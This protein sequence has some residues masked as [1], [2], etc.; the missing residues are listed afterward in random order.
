MA[1]GINHFQAVTFEVAGLGE[2]SLE[3]ICQQLNTLNPPKAPK[4]EDPKY[5]HVGWNKEQHDSA[6]A[7]GHSWHLDCVDCME[8]GWC[9]FESLLENQH[10]PKPGRSAYSLR[11]VRCVGTKGEEGF[12]ICR[13]FWLKAICFYIFAKNRFCVFWNTNK[14]KSGDE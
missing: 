7:E 1:H 12:K 9:K 8:C 4:F 11:L 13:Q 3:V 2:Q 14:P 10:L 5:F 6:R